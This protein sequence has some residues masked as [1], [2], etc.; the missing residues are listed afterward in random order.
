[1]N[2][3]LTTLPRPASV[4]HATPLLTQNGFTCTLL[5][6]EPGA[7]STLPDSRSPDD[8]LLFVLD[9]DIAVQANAVTTLVNQGDVFLLVAGSAPVVAAREGRRARVLRVEIPPRQVV[10]PQIITP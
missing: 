7:E 2:S 9:G 3:S 5:N 8:Q 1:M 6:L 10:T 4:L